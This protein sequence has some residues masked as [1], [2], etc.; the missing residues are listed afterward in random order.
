MLTIGPAPG[1]GCRS[2]SA[3]DSVPVATPVPMPCRTRAAIRP[4]TLSASAKTAIAAASVPIAASSTGRR[5]T[6][7]D[8][9]PV[10][11]RAA[12]S[13]TAYTAKTT[14]SVVGEKPNRAW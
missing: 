4:A 10:S 3:A 1:R 8:S 6:R 5:P 2:S 9:A 12:I 14:V 7:S 13:A 11:S